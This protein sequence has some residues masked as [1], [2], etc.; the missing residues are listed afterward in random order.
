MNTFSWVARVPWSK[1]PVLLHF[2]T[3]G[4]ARELG[5]SSEVSDRLLSV[6]ESC[7]LSHVW[8]KPHRTI[9]TSSSDPCR[10]LPALMSVSQLLLLCW[11]P[12]VV[13]RFWVAGGLGLRVSVERLAWS[14][15]SSGW[16]VD[17]M[18]LS[19]SSMVVGRLLSELP[20]A[21]EES[22]WD[23][24]WGQRGRVFSNELTISMFT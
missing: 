3:D 14:V 12:L 20:V 9:P 10:V 19:P 16:V 11:C 1:L 7:W 8:L 23:G 18:K 5:R 24:Y 22:L 13:W 2:F 17:T 21:R 4:G 15:S 6:S